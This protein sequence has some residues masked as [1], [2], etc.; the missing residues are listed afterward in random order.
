MPYRSGESLDDCSLTAVI[1][2]IGAQCGLQATELLSLVVMVL[3]GRDQ[4]GIS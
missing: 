1:A 4:G 2:R 3:A